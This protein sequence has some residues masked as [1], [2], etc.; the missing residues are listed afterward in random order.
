V[1]TRAE[2]RAIFGYVVASLRLLLAR[3][4][5]EG[6]DERAPGDGD[7]YAVNDEGDEDEEDSDET[8]IAVNRIGGGILLAGIMVGAWV[9]EE[10]VLPSQLAQYPVG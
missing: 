8:R 6:T 10:L 7:G 9:L 2:H 5:E 1:H 3:R 4:A